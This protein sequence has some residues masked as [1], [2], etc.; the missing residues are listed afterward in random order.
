MKEESFNSWLEAYGRAWQT[1]DAHAAAA[2]YTET[3]TYQV[4][5]FDE[6][7]R[8]K[9]AILE[10]W[11]GVVSTEQ[12]IEFG[13]EVLAVTESAGIARWWASFMRVPPALPTKLDGIFLIEMNDAGLCT[14]LREWWVKQQPQC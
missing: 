12:D 4:T 7:I 2:L 6:P 11:Q 8:G 1:R 10:Y 3:A 13:F 5:P 9:L 14:S